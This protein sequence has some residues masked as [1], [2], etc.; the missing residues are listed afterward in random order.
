MAESSNRFIPLHKLIE[1][2]IMERKNKNIGKKTT[3][4]LRLLA[5]EI[6]LTEETRKAKVI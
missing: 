5:L 6:P 3:E 1:D 2:Y 4:T